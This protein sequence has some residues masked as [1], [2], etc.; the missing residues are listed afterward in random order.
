MT[1]AAAALLRRLGATDTPVLPLADGAFAFAELDRPG[2][3]ANP[4]RRHLDDLVRNVAQAAGTGGL[5]RRIGTLGF[6]IAGTFGYRGDAETYDDLANADLLRVIDRRR[7]LPVAL[8]ILYIHVARAQ[9]WAAAGLNFP[10]HFLIR[11]SEGD[12]HAIIDPFSGGAPCDTERVERLLQELDDEAT[13]EPDHCRNVPDRDVLLRLQNNVKSRLIQAGEAERAVTVIERMLLLAPH[14][15]GLWYE[16]GV[17]N[18][19]L[20][21]LGAASTAL[22]RAIE[23][24]PASPQRDEAALLLRQIRGRLN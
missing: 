24:A 21:R 8:G 2:I 15:G 14:H 12:R 7:G 3:D 23:F 5:D 16:A 10:G 17:I 22:A 13:L 1:E 19:H 9:G 6:V 4:H 20:D 11:L 18:A